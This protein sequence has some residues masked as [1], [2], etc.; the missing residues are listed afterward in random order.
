MKT[1]KLGNIIKLTKGKKH[2]ETDDNSAIRYLQIEDLNGNAANKYTYETGVLVNTDDIIIAWDGANAGKV[3]TGLTGI[4]GSTLARMV[5][6]QEFAYTKFLYWFLNSKFDLIKSQRTG[7]TIPHI[8]NSAL[9]NLSVPLP[10]LEIQKKIAAILDKADELR[11]NDKKILEKYD[12]LAQSVFLDMF[13]DPVR[14]EKGWEI[15]TIEELVQKSRWAIKRGPFGGALKKEIFVDDGYLVYEQYH[16]L[17]NDFTFERYYIDEQKFQELKAFEVK[18]KDIIIS[19]SGVYLGKLAIVP[20]NAKKGIINQALL[21]ITLNEDIMKNEFFVYH[22]SH[23][24]FKEKFFKSDRGAGIPNLPPMTDFKKFPFI[25]PP[26]KD[27]IRFYNILQNIEK[28]RTSS[29][30]SLQKS[31]DLFQSL[32]QRAFKGELG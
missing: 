1:D 18:P 21:K 28:Q 14:N 27:Q 31:D 22:F 24:T 2:L 15:K 9:R 29:V 26:I 5:I 7:A 32:L 6:N 4:I 23:K 25:T 20:E 8:S 13:G 16:A 30:Q 12:Q 10:P 17:N 19:C 11:Q 3:G